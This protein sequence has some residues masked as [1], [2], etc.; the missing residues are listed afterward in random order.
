MEQE[1]KSMEH[2][3]EHEHKQER[4]RVQL[5]RVTFVGM[6]SLLGAL[7]SI[8]A[9]PPTLQPRACSSFMLA[10]GRLAWLAWLAG[11]LHYLPTY[12]CQV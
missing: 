12:L 11:H 6:F 1:A 4:V 10:R 2:E 7:S 8:P 9:L 3:H 5:P